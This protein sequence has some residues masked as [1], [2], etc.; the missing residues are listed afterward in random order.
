MENKTRSDSK[1]YILIG[2]AIMLSL[3][4]ILAVIALILSSIA[5]G[6]R[7]VPELD[8]DFYDPVYD[9]DIN[10]YPEYMQKDRSLYYTNEVKSKK[11]VNSKNYES[12]G[13]GPEFFYNYINSIKNGDAKLYNS[14][15]DDEYIAE[16]GKKDDFAPQMLYDI[17]LEYVRK[18]EID[19]NTDAIT[20][21]LEYCI[22]RN[23]GTFRRDI[24][25]GY[26]AQFITVYFDLSTG[27]GKIHSL[28]T[29][30]NIVR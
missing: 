15:F 24:G 14:Y 18:T 20:Y 8:Y 13:D 2:S 5:G 19:G 12:M 25:A 26:R 10:D 21:K 11:A 29:E 6:G 17:N 3:L 4:I 16:H 22:Y 28:Q 27:E 1:K 23:N 30:Y 9:L 7:E